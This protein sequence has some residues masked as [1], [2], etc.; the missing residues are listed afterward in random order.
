MFCP[1][2]SGPW[3]ASAAAPLLWALLE[4]EGVVLHHLQLMLGLALRSGESFARW[5]WEKHLLHK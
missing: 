2:C 5:S 1:R 3:R 4:V